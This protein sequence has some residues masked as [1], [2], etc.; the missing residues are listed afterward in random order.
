MVTASA[1]RAQLT[2]K[3]GSL[4]L[5]VELDAPAGALVL[6]GP[7]GA[8][9]TSSLL[10][11][12][13]VLRPSGGRIE[14]AGRVLF[15]AAAGVDVPLEQRQIAY[16]PQDYALFPHLSVRQNVAFGPESVASSEGRQARSER[17]EAL[18]AELGLGALAERRTTT[19]SGGEKQRVALARALAVRPR[20][21][22]TWLRAVRCAG[23]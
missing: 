6:V 13:G 17:V 11:L 15:D 12:L 9:K 22:W 3:V 18:L 4:A 8:G 21:P 5:A 10:M 1:L 16:V 7:N 23:F 14:L 19:L 2:G 20:A